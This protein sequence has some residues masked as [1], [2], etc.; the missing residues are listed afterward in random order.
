MAI[1]GIPFETAL[2]L[3]VA[4]EL[5]EGPLLDAMPERFPHHHHDTLLAKTGDVVSA[6]A[7][8]GLVKLIPNGDR[9]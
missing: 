1:A 7:G 3:S 8:Y 6:M 9:R 4:F 2:M 5:A